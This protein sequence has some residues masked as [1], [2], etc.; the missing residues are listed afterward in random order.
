M[1]LGR[2]QIS[3]K[4]HFSCDTVHIKQKKRN[5]ACSSNHP[6]Q[7]TTPNGHAHMR[8]PKLIVGIVGRAHVKPLLIG[9]MTLSFFHGV[10]LFY[11]IH[12][13]TY[14]LCTLFWFGEMLVSWWHLMCH[15][16][17]VSTVTSWWLTSTEELTW[18]MVIKVRDQ[19]VYFLLLE[20]KV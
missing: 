19:F 4:T 10:V 11:H 14:L 8:A 18:R 15:I 13:F 7:C 1:T 6:L 2:I 17:N 20:I 5:H 3:L 16:S 12:S 9:Y